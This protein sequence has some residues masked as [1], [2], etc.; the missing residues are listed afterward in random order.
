[1]SAIDKKCMEF[2]SANLYN[3]IYHIS[4]YLKSNSLKI[5]YIR[6]NSNNRI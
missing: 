6:L 1:M 5:L 4:Q 2:T 3:I